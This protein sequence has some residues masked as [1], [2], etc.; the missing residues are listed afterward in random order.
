MGTYR[1]LRFRV[2]EFL[3][4]ESQRPI[5]RAFNFFIII[6]IFTNV[7]A[8]ILE[9]HAPYHNSYGTFFSI[10][11]IFSVVVFS[12]EYLGRLWSCV[13]NEDYKDMSASKARLRYIFSPLAIIDLLAI[14]PFYLSLFISIDMRH[15]RML[16]MLR[17]LKLSHYFKGLDIFITVISKELVT[18]A[19]VILTVLIMV[20]L[21]ASLMYTLEHTAQPEAFKDIPRAIW[22]AVVT[23]TTVGYGDVTP[24]TFG[25]RVLAGFIMLMGVGVVALPAGMLAARF[26][27]E[28]QARKDRMRS[29]VLHA[30]EDGRIDEWEMVELEKTARRL[31]ISMDALNRLI[32]LHN[33]QKNSTQHC[34]HC[35]KMIDKAHEK[36]D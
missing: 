23:M 5:H 30:L 25:G 6:L 17:L 7:I 12:F 4:G 28:I 33:L 19:T 31:G 27:E 16:R 22:W 14:L 34:P 24:V 3:D 21:S 20:I 36:L 2:Y 35:G 1:T 10:F 15:L 11:E 26:G 8:V 9:S 13:E 32:D 18:I 29:H